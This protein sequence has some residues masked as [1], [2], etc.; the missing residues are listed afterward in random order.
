M[1]GERFV[2]VRYYEEEPAYEQLFDL[3]SDPMQLKNLALSPHRE[4]FD[5]EL[6]RMRARCDELLSR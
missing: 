4:S 3:E 5:T 1:R 2:Y 6:M